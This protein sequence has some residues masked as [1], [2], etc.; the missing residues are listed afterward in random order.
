V[1][2]GE[3]NTLRNLRLFLGSPGGLEDEREALFELVDDL[4]LSLRRI[5]WQIEV[6]GWE[7]RGPAGGRAQA[8]INEDVDRAHVFCGVLGDRW[9]T[10]TGEQTSGFAEEW[11]RSVDRFRR[12]GRPQL[13]LFFKDVSPAQLADPG[14][15]LRAV[16]QFREQ[17]E[18]EESAFHVSFRDPEEFVGKVRRSLLDLVFQKAGI[19]AAAKLPELDW[20][21]A[22]LGE[23]ASL[24]A[25]G[26][27]RERLAEESKER[28]PELA[29]KLFLD[30]A[31]ELEQSGFGEA[32]DGY[33]RRGASALSAAGRTEDAVG[34]WRGVLA[35]A[36]SRSHPVEAAFAARQLGEELPPERR[37]ESRAW[38]ACANWAEDD[39]RARAVLAEALREASDANVDEKTIE[40]WRET[41]WQIWLDRGEAE[42][43]V[44]DA[45][46]HR[47]TSTEQEI[48][49][50]EARSS[51]DSDRY[52][53]HW[54][55]LRERSSASPNEQRRLAAQIAARWAFELARRGEIE[56]S[57]EEYARAAELWGEVAGG[58]EEA[59]ECFF[60]AQSAASLGGEIF[61]SGWGWRPL[62]AAMRGDH[63]SFA[64]R[65]AN[66]ERSGL[67][68]QLRR[69]PSDAREELR[70]AIRLRRQGGHLRGWLAA[71]RTLGDCERASEESA[72]AALA[73]CACGD[74]R[75]AKEA[76]GEGPRR[77]LC[78][79]L[80]I[81][82][83]EWSTRA[84][85]AVLAVV[86]RWASEERATALLPELLDRAA[87]EGD[88]AGD[89][90]EAV[91][92]LGAI[93]VALPDAKLG[94]ATAVLED[95][96]GNENR[97]ASQAAGSA[98][99]LLAES[100][101]IDPSP[102]LISDFAID[103]GASAMGPQW[104]AEHL[105]SS[106]A[107]TEIRA[108]ALR[109]EVV[110]LDA[111]VR[112]GE[113]SGDA[114]LELACERYCRRIIESDLG[115]DEEGHIHG[116][117]DLATTGEVASA[118]PSTDARTEVAE[119][120]LLY[121]LEDYWPAV[122]RAAALHGL[123]A[124]AKS[125]DPTTY[126][127]RIRPLLSL[128]VDAFEAAADRGAEMFSEP[129]EVEAAALYAVADL[130]GEDPPPWLRKTAAEARVSRHRIM[131]VAAWESA[132]VSQAL[133]IDGLELAL[134]DPKVKVR[135]AAIFCWRGRRQELPPPGALTRLAEDDFTEVR[136]LD[137][138]PRYRS[139]VGTRLD[140]FASPG[141][142]GRMGS[143]SR[144]AR[145]KARSRRFD[146]TGRLKA[147]AGCRGEPAM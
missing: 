84:S 76:A 45:E 16:L 61:P 36:L 89:L 138:T 35:R 41:L 144:K 95:M 107:K 131:R 62:A 24:L 33:R 29:A 119:K 53:E 102:R 65:A 90:Q 122:N 101:R 30:L 100:G 97:L 145:T 19:G 44:A 126:V 14:E 109:G 38:E 3:T 139:V 140:P 11:E 111:L 96:L 77:E 12:T 106:A 31:E 21:A 127:E 120:L 117:M 55:R 60:S 48:L 1:S 99:W 74:G 125:L 133:P 28:D 10:P 5:D 80:P 93:S 27:A 70:R 114:E 59:G 2:G 105:D 128:D 9:G 71:Q 113:V 46:I 23:P 54:Q 50:A 115:R 73:Y 4:N 143:S 108:A 26:P 121:A 68:A 146:L 123:R 52:R 137:P 87:R 91:A 39:E 92:S 85:L 110:A 13:W 147:G 51:R 142:P 17:V 130:S 98:L 83:T 67:S 22:L 132:R 6:L 129:G 57:R 78:D 32:A 72:A 124:L 88:Y 86:G 112:S 37:W 56:E 49:A 104:I 63:D 34:H 42:A 79:Q 118:A 18:H 103:P 136:G 69:Q 81:G 58:Q 141:G 82:E 66:Y 43:I 64:A 47:P 135:A 75:R 25:K 15:Q 20:R 94:I 8:E 134:F 40:C 116:L 7:N